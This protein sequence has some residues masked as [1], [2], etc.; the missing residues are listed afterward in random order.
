M[1]VVI[2]E[3]NYLLDPCV[4]SSTRSGECRFYS[5][6]ICARVNGSPERKPLLRGGTRISGALH[7]GKGTLP[8]HGAGAK[9]SRASP[10]VRE[11]KR[12]KLVQEE[13]KKEKTHRRLIYSNLEYW[14]Y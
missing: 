7:A 6:K 3:E 1:L 11:E 9:C 14:H 5:G 13:K 8:F 10:V 12:K 2:L 4:V